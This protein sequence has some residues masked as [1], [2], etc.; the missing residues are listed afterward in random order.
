MHVLKALV[1][2]PGGGWTRGDNAAP[3]EVGDIVTIWLEGGRYYEWPDFLDA[4]KAQHGFG[5]GHVIRITRGEDQE[6]SKRGYQPRKVWT[7][8]GR[9]PTAEDG[10]F[11][12]QCEQAHMSAQSS[13]PLDTGRDAG[14]FD[15][16]I[17]ADQ[18]D[19]MP[20]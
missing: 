10:E 14:P 11:T 19:E 16:A 13:T 7:F 8:A 9:G 6:A 15:S 5:V 1:K 4:H 20:F 2:D 3:L 12:K 17:A 18:A